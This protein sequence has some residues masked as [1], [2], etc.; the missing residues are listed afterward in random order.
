M[1]LYITWWVMISDGISDPI[2]FGNPQMSH[3][4]NRIFNRK[5]GELIWHL[6]Q[7]PPPSQSNVIFFLNFPQTRHQ[8]SFPAFLHI[9]PFFVFLDYSLIFG[10][11]FAII[12]LL[13]AAFLLKYLSIFSQKN[14]VKP[15]SPQ[16]RF[17]LTSSHLIAARYLCSPPNRRE[18]FQT[19]KILGC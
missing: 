2:F 12:L 15:F 13:Y 19:G 1:G 8:C 17:C 6:D 9:S 7:S 5:P 18:K 16:V 11:F 10:L 14:Y 4:Y 3:K